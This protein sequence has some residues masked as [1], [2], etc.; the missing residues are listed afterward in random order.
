MIH[1]KV[2]SEESVSAIQN[3]YLTA[4][5]SHAKGYMWKRL[6]TLIDMSQNLEANAIKDESDIFEKVGMNQDDYL[7]A[8]HLYFRYK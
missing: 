1:P 5:N 6:G 4:F 8:I 2:C 3:R 7:P